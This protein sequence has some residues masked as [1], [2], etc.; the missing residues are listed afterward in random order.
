[1]QHYTQSGT[2]QQEVVLAVDEYPGGRLDW[3]TFDYRVN[4][5]GSPVPALPGSKADDTWAERTHRVS[6]ACR[7]RSRSAVCP[8]RATGRWK[9]GA[10]T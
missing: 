2:A 10:S 5:D 9:K 4:A 8:R 1:M 3:S 7:R 6:R